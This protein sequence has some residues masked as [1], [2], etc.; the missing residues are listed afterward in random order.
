MP[1]PRQV[2]KHLSADALVCLLRNRFATITDQ[3]QGTPTI[4]LPDALMSAYAMFALKDPSL[5]AFD[6]RRISSADN[7]LAVR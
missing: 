3:R 4:S 1:A 5:L 7:L 6:Q 2:R